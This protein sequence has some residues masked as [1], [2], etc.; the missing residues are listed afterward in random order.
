MAFWAQQGRSSS[1]ADPKDPRAKLLRR[2]RGFA[3]FWISILVAYFIGAEFFFEKEKAAATDAIPVFILL[4]CCILVGCIWH[5]GAIVVM[6]L[7]GMFDK[8]PW[9]R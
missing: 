1:Q 2:F 4:A 9:D 5:V 6:S 3:L 8:R 7:N